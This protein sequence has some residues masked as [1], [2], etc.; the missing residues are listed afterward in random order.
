MRQR[1]NLASV[2]EN[3]N[4]I[5]EEELTLDDAF[6]RMSMESD[7]D[8]RTMGF[9]S[10]YDGNRRAGNLRQ[11]QGGDANKE[12]IYGTTSMGCPYVIDKWHDA[13]PQGR[14]SVQVQ[15]VS[16]NNVFSKTS[17]RVSTD[18]MSLIV[19]MPMSPYL[20][21]PDYAFNSYLVGEW[22][23]T[24]GVGQAIMTLNTHPKI[25]ARKLSVSKIRE[26]EPT[27]KEVIY[28]QRIPLPRKCHHQFADDKADMYFHGKKFVKY[29]DGSVHLHVELL[30]VSGDAY[31]AQETI[32]QLVQ[33]SVPADVSPGGVIPGSVGAV[34]QGEEMSIV[35]TDN[36][37]PAVVLDST[38]PFLRGAPRYA[39]SA[40]RSNAGDDGQHSVNTFQRK[41]M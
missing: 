22:P 34:Q 41:E 39:K 1:S 10:A 23:N 35:G 13:R 24:L 19:S 7:G 6:T 3:N 37:S 31:E 32:P 29:P 28:E 2:A 9:K 8:T 12:T 16:G 20:A 11:K 5:E 14:V 26:R 38:S 30:S 18:Q 25:I 33:A 17:V 40:K 27:K 15:L 4:E 36:G 21:R